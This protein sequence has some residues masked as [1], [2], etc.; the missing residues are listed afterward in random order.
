VPAGAFGVW[1]LYVLIL[2]AAALPDGPDAEIRVFGVAVPLAATNG[3]MSQSFGDADA[4]VYAKGAKEIVDYGWIKQPWY[5]TLWPPGFFVFQAAVLT[6]VGPHGPALAAILIM[7]VMVWAAA[8][9]LLHHLCRTVFSA[10][11]SFV[12]PLC[13]VLF[14]FFREYFLRSGVVFSETLSAALWTTGFVLILLAAVHRS[15]LRAIA[16]GVLFAAAA[17]VRASVDLVLLLGSLIVAAD[18]VLMVLYGCRA[19]RTNHRQE[20]AR[21]WSNPEWR[22]ILLAVL[23]FHAATMPYR[24]YKAWKHQTV[25]FTAADYYYRYLWQPPEEYT[26]LQGFIL[27]GGGPV[28]C[29]T[30]P[31][32]CEELTLDRKARGDG[33]HSA[34]LYKKL[35]FAGLLS[36]PVRWVAYRAKYLPKYWFSR[37]SASTP[38]RGSLVPGLLLFVAL[39]GSVAC[40]PFLL[41]KRFGQFL[42]YSMGMVYLGHFIMFLFLHYEVRYLYWLQSSIVLFAISIAV[43][44]IG[45]RPQN[46]TLAGT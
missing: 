43:C 16:A 2:L 29:I 44:L 9:T 36:Q 37:P 10:G 45:G 7:T 46:R 41:S 42:L 5:T 20:A 4:A 1:A 30:N 23:A 13:F 15:S 17:Y 22:A 25:M 28:A 33:A 34:E 35:A 6:L 32:I 21:L 12:L 19:R 27:E 14:P 26:P 39:V 11:V 8:F 38:V 40:A 18:Y 24:I 3:Q 31:V